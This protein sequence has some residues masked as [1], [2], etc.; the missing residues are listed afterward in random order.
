MTSVD[1]TL[2]ATAQVQ[3]DAMASA[4]PRIDTE[5]LTLRAPRLSDWAVLEPIWTT[6]RARH[7][8]GPFSVEDAWLD[9]SQLCA[10]WML[11][12]FGGLTIT[13]T[14]TGDVLGMVLLGHEIK[15]PEPEL[16]WLLTEEAEGHGYATEAALALRDEGLRLFGTGKFVS[17]VEDNNSR[18]IALAERIDAVADAARHPIAPEVLVYR[19]GHKGGPA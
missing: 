5:R 9:F 7:I 8:G 2:H 19:H 1:L 14:E 18:S 13:L 11:R 17:Y 3:I 15:D 6:D 4:L 12:G 10:S 16:G